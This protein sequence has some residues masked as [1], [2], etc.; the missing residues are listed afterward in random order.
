MVPDIILYL[1]Q[2]STSGRGRREI[3]GVSQVKKEHAGNTLTVLVGPN[4]RHE[5]LHCSKEDYSSSCEMLS[6]KISAS[7]VAVGTPCN[8][9]IQLL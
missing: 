7:L 2:G 5:L 6:L 9:Q 8:A 1:V 4:M 3:S